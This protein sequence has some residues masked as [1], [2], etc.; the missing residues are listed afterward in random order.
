MGVTRREIDTKLL[1]IHLSQYRSVVS[2]PLLHTS[3]SCQKKNQVEKGLERGSK[4]I[5]GNKWFLCEGILEK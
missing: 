3:D 2:P 4:M 5:T 1:N